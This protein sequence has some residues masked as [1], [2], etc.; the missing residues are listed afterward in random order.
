MSELSDEKLVQQCLEGN[1]K[2]YECLVNKYQEVIFNTALRMIN[3]YDDAK[4]VTQTVFIKGFEKLDTFN[5]S[6]KF[7]SW[8]YRMTINES[9]NFIKSRKDSELI[10]EDVMSQEKTP[11]H[12]FVDRET[13][14]KIDNAL[15][16][17]NLDYRV[18]VVLR[19][20]VELSY[21]E[22]SFIL[23]T[24]EKT[25]KSRLYSARKMLNTI[26]VEQGA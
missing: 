12:I 3:N 11:E 19:H 1:S 20:F 10:G 13:S 2:A 24:P 9:I 16:K 17:L 5:N 4:D 26:M 25:I 23:D 15:M 21:R 18:V 8:I 7:F 6:H 22:I 14:K